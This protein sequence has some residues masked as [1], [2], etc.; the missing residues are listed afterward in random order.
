MRGEREKERNM[1][2][3]GVF[4]LSKEEKDPGH[5]PMQVCKYDRSISLFL[6]ENI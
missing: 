1:L 5:I 6:G 3:R 4:F 2:K